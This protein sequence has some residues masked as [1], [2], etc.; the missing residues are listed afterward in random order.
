MI[1]A[2]FSYEISPLRFKYSV[3]GQ[4]RSG[5]CLPEMAQR[6]ALAAWGP[7]SRPEPERPSRTIKRS[8]NSRFPHSPGL[9]ST[10]NSKFEVRTSDFDFELR[11]SNPRPHH[12]RSN[13]SPQNRDKLIRLNRQFPSLACIVLPT[14]DHQGEP[15]QRLAGLLQSS[16]LSF[17]S[18]S[19]NFE[20]RI[21]SRIQ[22]WRMA[23]WRN[24]EFELES[25]KFLRALI[26][27]A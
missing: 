3:A 13:R 18:R 7:A 15:I 11:L 17:R 25:F 26:E 19:S 23:E 16:I 6:G 14:S 5:A 10:W 20:L 9:Y 21:R 1:Q 24:R 12:R 4:P 22:I 8:S 2:G 27:P